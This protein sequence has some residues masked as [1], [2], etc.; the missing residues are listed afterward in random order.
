[1]DTR[2]TYS[3]ISADYAKEPDRSLTQLVR[4][5]NTVTLEDGRKFEIRRTRKDGLDLRPLQK[6]TSLR[7]GE[8]VMI[9]GTT[10]K[11]VVKAIFVVGA[12]TGSTY[13]L[14]A[15]GIQSK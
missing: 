8:R 11:G 12:R 6:G 1:M 14:R 9:S 5:V 7:P 13:R 15:V 3:K 2:K 4:Y 10:E